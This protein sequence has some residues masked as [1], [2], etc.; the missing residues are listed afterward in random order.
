M[1]LVKVFCFPKCQKE[2][3]FLPFQNMLQISQLLGYA[4]HNLG[5]CS[6]ARKKCEP[7]NIFQMKIL[8][9]LQGAKTV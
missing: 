4:W 6:H 8:Q 3:F 1:P 5:F 7:E 9:Q 2:I